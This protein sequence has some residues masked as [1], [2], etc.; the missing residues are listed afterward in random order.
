M[1]FLNSSE[2]VAPYKPTRKGTWKSLLLQERWVPG[3]KKPLGV[4]SEETAT[5]KIL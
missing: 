5:L 3:Q 2:K 4:R 1:K